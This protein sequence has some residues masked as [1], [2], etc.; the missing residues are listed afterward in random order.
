[1]KRNI[2]LAALLCSIPTLAMAQDAPAQG[3]CCKN[4]EA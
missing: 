3:L 4:R 1:M 2:I